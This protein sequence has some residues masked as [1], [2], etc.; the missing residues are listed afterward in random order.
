MDYPPVQK[1]DIE[2]VLL[3]QLLLFSADIY[4]YMRHTT[5]YDPNIGPLLQG[6]IQPPVQG[7]G[8]VASIAGGGTVGG[9][10]GKQ[11]PTPAEMDALEMLDLRYFN[12]YDTADH[13]VLSYSPSRANLIYMYL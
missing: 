10:Y 3:W 9:G 4:L 1:P 2:F 7:G 12:D 6:S 5:L 11:P 13:T 8:A